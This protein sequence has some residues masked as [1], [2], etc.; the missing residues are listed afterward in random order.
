MVR[1]ENKKKK[2]RKEKEDPS[3]RAHYRTEFGPN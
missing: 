1:R 2:V 3:I